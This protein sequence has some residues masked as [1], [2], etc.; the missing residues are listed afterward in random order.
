VQ[1]L[2]EYRTRGGR[3][4]DPQRLRSARFCTKNGTTS[5]NGFVGAAS[6]PVLKK[7]FVI[8]GNGFIIEPS[9]QIISRPYKTDL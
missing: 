5:G 6:K 1:W 4:F 8:S 3:R 2:E 7:F 9:L